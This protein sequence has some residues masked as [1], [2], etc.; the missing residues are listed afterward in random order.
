MIAVT[1]IALV[2]AAIVFQAWPAAQAQTTPVPSASSQRALLD[3]YCVR[4][5]SESTRNQAAGLMLDKIDVERVSAD[6]E[7]WEKIVRKLRVGNHPMAGSPR[8][9]RAAM[10]ALTDAIEDALERDTRT[11]WAGGGGGVGAVPLS[12]LDLAARLSAFLWRSWPDAELLDLAAAGK[13]RT[14]AVLEQQARRMLKDP[15]SE[16]MFSNFFSQW[17]LLQNVGRAN[18]SPQVVGFDDDLRQS[19]RRETE[20]FL[21]NQVQEDRSITDLLTADHTFLN[22]RLAKHYGL[23]NVRGAEF[24]RVAM[25]RSQRAGILGHASILTITSYSTRTSPVVRGK[26]LAETFLGVPMPTP[27]ANV[28]ALPEEAPGTETPMRERMAQHTRN[29]VC[30]ACH[31]G[32]DP[33]G[34]ALESF[35]AVG[36]WRERQG[37]F[38]IDDAAMLPDGTMMDGPT[39]IRRVLAED[40]RTAYVSTVTERLMN[41]ALGR[42]V[43]YYD[44]PSIRTIVREAGGSDHRWSSLILGI[45]RSAPF[46]MKRSDR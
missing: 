23:P 15:R 33:F 1:R 14:P 36:R 39:G 19:M 25:G 46:Q 24:R 4:C 2:A 10:D 6:A 16:A 40:R 43:G 29:P 38:T 9:D 8:P 3:E 17:L 37:K 28:P 22:E 34:L 21:R 18:P 31:S 7:V 20:L 45:V 35:D 5:H 11:Y 26:W 30:A 12:D 41:H 44:M 13:L 32:M 42:R 27:P